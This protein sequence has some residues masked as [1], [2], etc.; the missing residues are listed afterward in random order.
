MKKRDFIFI[1]LLILFLSCAGEKN[2]VKK[3]D[4]NGKPEEVIKTFEPLSM[5]KD[6]VDIPPPKW[7]TKEINY[8]SLLPPKLK[9]ADTSVVSLEEMIQ[10]WRVQ[11]GGFFKTEKVE[12]AIGIA[13]KARDL[14]EEVVYLEFEAPFYKVRVGDCNSRK[15]A[16]ALLEKVKKNGFSDAL[17]I[18]TRV[19]KYPELRKQRE[20][21]KKEA[22]MDTVNAVPKMESDVKK[23]IKN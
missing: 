9:I 18:P 14:L 3:E 1:V 22:E 2:T 17:I 20:L 13:D 11:I 12:N 10:G 16:N 4:E 7:E 5:L 21:E 19:Y 8:E 6:D 15:D 23:E